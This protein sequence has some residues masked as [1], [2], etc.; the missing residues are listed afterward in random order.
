M[1]DTTTPITERAKKIGYREFQSSTV[2]ADQQLA[3]ATN[4]IP[5]R[6]CGRHRDAGGYDFMQPRK[7]RKGV[8]R[9][10]SFVCL[11]QLAHYRVF[12]S[13]RLPVIPDANK[14]MFR[15]AFRR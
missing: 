3:N 4:P 14:P 8:N 12:G 2:G 13:D 11:I 10:G 15:S 5:K 6:D 7:V 1:S 9:S